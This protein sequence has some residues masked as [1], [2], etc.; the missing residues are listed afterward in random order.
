MYVCVSLHEYVYIY[1][2]VVCMFVCST[3]AR[4]K[5]QGAWLNL[6]FRWGTWPAQSVKHETPDL[7]VLSSSPT[8]G[9]EPTFKKFVF[10]LYDK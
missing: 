5:T 8:M 2:Y 1:I 3:I 7:A 4:K 10:Q 6:N 9:L